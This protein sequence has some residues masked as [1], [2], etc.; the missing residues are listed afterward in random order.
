MHESSMK[1]CVS[2]LSCGLSMVVQMCTMVEASASRGQGLL[3]TVQQEGHDAQAALDKYSQGTCTNPQ[4]HS[5]FWA[6]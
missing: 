3:Q 2:P 5:I 1:T 4:N 6:Q